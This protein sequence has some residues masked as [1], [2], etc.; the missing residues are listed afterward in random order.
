[1][2]SALLLGLVA[3]APLMTNGKP[4]AVHGPTALVF[5]T[6]DCPICREYSP[7][8]S[9]LAAFA[10][11]KHV[12][13]YLVFSEPGIK[14]KDAV[15]HLKEFGLPQ[16]AVL[17]GSLSFAKK[18]GAKVTPTAVLWDGKNLLYS[19]RIN[20]LYPSIGKRRVNPTTHEFRDA[21]AAAASHHAIKVSRTEAVGCTISFPK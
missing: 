14:A 11:S 13:F 9:R 6:S 12:D 4:F 7:E 3:Q 21:I 17:D 20:D 10:G 15:A 8:I 16:L 5:I 1:M 19:G 18:L 2:I